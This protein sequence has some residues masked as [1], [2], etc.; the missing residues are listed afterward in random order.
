M[1]PFLK[2]SVYLQAKLQPK[3]RKGTAIFAILVFLL[4]QYARQISYIECRLANTFT[5]ASL[6]CDCE[7]KL[8]DE[9]AADSNKPIKE[10]RH[11][12]ADDYFFPDV[13]TPNDLG[14]HV[15]IKKTTAYCGKTASGMVPPP[16]Q[17]PRI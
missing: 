13:K 7:K 14:N 1:H 3:L 6:R 8:T 4:S 15:V 17:P 10:H 11:I 9:N 5:P 2:S 16:F 12:H